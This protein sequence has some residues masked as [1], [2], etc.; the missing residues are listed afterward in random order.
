MSNIKPLQIKVKLAGHQNKKPQF[1]QNVKLQNG[2][3]LKAA[4]PKATRALVALMDMY[5]VLGGAASHYGGPAALADLMSALHA[6]VFNEAEKQNKNWYEVAHIVNDAGHCENGLYALKANY[7]M[8]GLELNSLKKFRSIDSGLT[9][10]GEVHCFEQGVY[11]SNGPLGSAFPQS[12]GLALADKLSGQMNRVTFCVLSDGAAMEGEAKEA[13]AAIPGL[14]KRGM[15]SPFVLIISDNNTK[16]S[17]RIDTDA[18]SMNP[19]FAGLESLGWKLIKLE[20]GN[21][22]QACTT[23][24]EKA[25]EQALQN[26]QQPI[27]IWAKTIKGIGTKK[28]AE[29]ASGGHGFPCKSPTE[30]PDFIKEIYGNEAAPIIFNSW[31]EELIGMEKQIK[32]NAKPDSGEKIQTGISK[33]MINAFKKGLPV[34]SVTSDLPG[35]T[36]V[37]GF[38]KEFPQASLDMGVAESNMVSAAAGLSK[39]GYIPVVDTFAQFGVTK[40]ALPL[41]MAMLSEAPVIGVFSHTGFQDAAD[42][43]SHQA[44]S[45]MSMLASIP[46]VDLYSLC[47]SEEADA[48]MTQVIEKFAFDRVAGKKPNSSIFFLGRENFPKSFKNEKNNIA[49]NLAELQILADNS[50]STKTVALLTT[51]SLVGEALQASE[52]LKSKNIGSIVLNQ[53]CLNRINTDVLSNVLSRCDGRIVTVEDHQV[54]MGLGTIVAHQ[55]AQANVPFKMKSLGVHGEFGQSAYN[56]ID[57][58]RKHGIDSD[59]IVKAAELI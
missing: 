32:S 44:L 33:A 52:K 26:P 27:V 45:Y 34:I 3:E 17:G 18:F 51:G 2:Q 16:L 49:Y 41:T 50:N 38:R 43:A 22:L 37:A 42:G 19:T 15:T 8:A 55:L 54:L 29:S 56:A 23:S 25:M 24:I 28:T 30:L 48:L 7:S 1:A 14:A 4:D 36:G 35:S 6:I 21:D 12:Q 13:M 57:L 10:H 59:A 47:S 11:L 46:G 31:I 5:A 9:G 53:N 20:N 40:G 39:Q 58:Y